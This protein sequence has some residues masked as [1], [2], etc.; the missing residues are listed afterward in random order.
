MSKPC[1]TSAWSTF[2]IVLALAG[3][4]V[5]SSHM[6]LAAEKC[7]ELICTSGTAT[8]AGK[9]WKAN[10][11]MRLTAPGYHHMNLRIHGRAQ[12]EV[13]GPGNVVESLVLDVPEGWTGTYA[14]QACKLG[15]PHKKIC[16][17]W[18]TYQIELPKAL[19]TPNADFCN[20]YAS[21]AVARVGQAAKCG[22][23]GGRWD[24]N[25]QSHTAWCLSQ[26]SQQQAWS[27]HNA[28]LGALAD[29]AKKEAAA[30]S[31]APSKGNQSAGAP[32]VNVKQDVDVY[33]LPGG[34]G[35]AFGTLK[36][37]ARP[38]LYDRRPDQWC[39]VAGRD[40]PDGGGWVWCGAGFELTE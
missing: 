35:Q 22:L 2:A 40:V 37:G 16:N 4:V 38:L 10:L 14:V 34:V 26:S 5:G 15:T 27:E 28:R 13:D 11:K 9:G 1:L 24:P 19:S 23:T 31:S 21:E 33:K 8:K 6:V 29:C 32:V 18:V 20:W 36:S 39:R 7:A 17:D 3:G 30:G 12:M 25:P